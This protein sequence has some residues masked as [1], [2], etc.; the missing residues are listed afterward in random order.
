MDYNN[1]M[2]DSIVFSLIIF[3]KFHIV[4]KNVIEINLYIYIWY[5]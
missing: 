3:K 4:Y 2:K 5:V 1:F